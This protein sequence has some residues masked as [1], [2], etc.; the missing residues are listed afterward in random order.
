MF[1][2]FTRA[3][4]KRGGRNKGDEKKGSISLEI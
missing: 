3:W 4:G 1:V 2:Y